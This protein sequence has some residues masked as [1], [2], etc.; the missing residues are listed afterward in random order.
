MRKQFIAIIL[1]FLMVLSVAITMLNLFA[2][3]NGFRNVKDYGPDGTARHVDDAAINNGSMNLTS[4][5]A[6]FV[7]ADSGHTVSVN[8]AGAAGV[9]LVTTISSITNSTTVVLAA[10]ASTTVSGRRCIIGKDNT[11]QFITAI[12]AMSGKTLYIPP[13]KYVVRMRASGSSP[14]TI[15][16]NTTVIGEGPGCVIY[17]IGSDGKNGGGVDDDQK[18]GLYVVD[19]SLKIDISGLHFIGENGTSSGFSTPSQN[20]SNF[21]FMPGVGSLTK[22]VDIHDCTFEQ[23]FGFPVHNAGTGERINARNCRFIECANGLN[24]NADYSQQTGN[25]LYK[26]ESIEA[27]GAYSTISN[28]TIIQPGLVGISVGGRTAAPDGPGTVVNGN[29]IIESGSHGIVVADGFVQGVISNNTIIKAAGDGILLTGGGY[30]PLTHNLVIGNE[31]ISAG[32]NGGSDY[33]GIFIGTDADYTRVAGNTSR[34]GGYSGFTQGYGIAIGAPN[35]HVAANSFKGTIKD[36]RLVSTNIYFGEDNICDQSSI[37]YGVGCSLISPVFRGYVFQLVN[38]T[39]TGF[40]DVA[41]PTDTIVSG[42][43]TYQAYNTGSGQQVRSGVARFSASNNAGT[44]ATEIAIINEGV[45]VSS[46][47]LTL[48]LSIVTAT[49]KITIKATGNSSVFGGG[50]HFKYTIQNESSQAITPL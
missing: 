15:P 39:A 6:S 18:S 17:C 45:S 23:S 10:A 9:P 8:G 35:C 28:N 49:N 2:S 42:T 1:T 40:I 19:G 20:Q 50:V 38:T 29:T 37:E 13:G 47:T 30:R 44:Y 34:D 22:D 12:A 36:V 3:G 5:T 27:S 16:S 24:V 43:I 21:I 14:L 26:T 32:I 7:A 41:L 48:A 11:N 25:Y 33:T 4:A 31:I 46:G